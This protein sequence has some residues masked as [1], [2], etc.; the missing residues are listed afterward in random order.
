MDT[1]EINLSEDSSGVIM[2]QF[3]KVYQQNASSL[4]LLKYINKKEGICSVNQAHRQTTNMQLL[5]LMMMNAKI[6]NQ[7]QN[8]HQFIYQM[9]KIL[10]LC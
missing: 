2:I 9:Y 7:H 8:L 5:A 6:M 10:V 1:G 4:N 3:G